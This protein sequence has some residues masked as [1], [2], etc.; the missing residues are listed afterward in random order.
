MSALI[1]Y[2]YNE[3]SSLNRHAPIKQIHQHQGETGAR[4]RCPDM[5]EVHLSVVDFVHSLYLA[6]VDLPYQRV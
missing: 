1:R 2:K 5:K 4:N 3:L 6:M